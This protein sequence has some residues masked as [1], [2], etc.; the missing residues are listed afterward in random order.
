M[1]APGQ[2]VHDGSPDP[3]AVPGAVDQYEVEA[4]RGIGR[5]VPWGVVQ[6]GLLI[7]AC[8]HESTVNRR[9]DRA[10]TQPIDGCFERRRLLVITDITRASHLIGTFH[11]LRA[12]MFLRL[13]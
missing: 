1:A 11:Y 5:V 2:F 12:S 6:A 8:V 9:R 13:T 7:D 3:A 10:A 4:E